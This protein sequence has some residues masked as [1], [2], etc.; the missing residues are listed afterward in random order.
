MVRLLLSCG[1]RAD[2]QDTQGTTALM[3]ACERGHTH[4]VRLLLERGHCDLALTDKVS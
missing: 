4:I 3:F 1:A 2:V